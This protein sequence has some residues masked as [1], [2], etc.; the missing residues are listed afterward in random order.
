MF[1]LA[2]AAVEGALA[3]GATYADA[4][5]V[6]SASQYLHARNGELDAL[7][8]SESA[9]VGVRAL[10]GSS[11]G[12]F[13]TCELAGAAVRAAGEDAAAI[14]R[15][16]GA[17]PGPPLELADVPVTEDHWESGWAEHPG[18][19][20]LAEKGDVL[21]TATATMA[22]VAGVSVGEASMTSWETEKW[23]ASSQGHRI[24]QHLVECGTAMS[25]TAPGERET[26]RRSWGGIGG[27]FGTRGYEL[28]RE[29]DLAGNA[30]RV[31]E[32]AVALLS[33]PA[34]PEGVTD[35]VLG[36]EQLG[37]QIHES[38]G[39]A[40]ELDRI[41]GWEAAFAGTSFLDLA[42]LGRFRLGSE[43]MNVTADATLPG[44]LGSFGYDDEGTPAQ[45]VD[46]VR[47]GRWIGV[48]SGRD[49][50]AR[51]G[52]PPGGMV[53]ADGYARLPMVRMTNVGILPGESSLEEMVADTADGVYMETN[54][55]WSIDDKRLNFQFG[56]EVGREI[57]NGRLGRLLRNPTYTG[58]TPRFWASLDRLGNADEWIFWGTPNCGKGQPQQFGHTG[59]PAVPAR[60]RG[61]RVGVRG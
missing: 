13:A 8:G 33:A 22:G 5:G 43:L 50:A 23:F 40:I 55:S 29:A 49:S 35:L 48:L 47:D 30:L 24:S 12:F 25:A 60:F 10:V 36:P 46:I 16:S 19:V 26:Q 32:E 59:H 1:D 38:V 45:R 21:V 51:A 37:L 15:A 2:T 44:A 34:C 6:L 11:W 57:K 54:R 39:H 56:C 20:S 17:V 9:G 31:A 41:L 4:R 3:A 27:R 61:V 7:R 42:G 14:A 18:S 58:V 53:R 52:L 28:V